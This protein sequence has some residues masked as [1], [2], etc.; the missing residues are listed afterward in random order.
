MLQ[1]LTAKLKILP[2]EQDFQ[3]LHD[4]MRAYADACSFVAQKIVSDQIP[5]SN[6]KIHKAMYK[7]CRSEFD[8]PSQ[9]SESVIRTVVASFKSIQTNLERYPHKFK[10]HKRK[11]GEIIPQFKVP[12]L[13]LVW[14]RDYS[15]VWNKERTERLFSVNTLKGRIKVPFRSDAME[16]AFAEGARFGTAKLEFKHG[17]FFLHIPVTVE[18][19]DL[20]WPSQFKNVV[21]IDRGIRFLTVA[22]DGKQTSFAS[23][24]TVKQKR[25][26]YKKKREELQKRHTPAA[27]RRIHSMGQR[28]N[29]WMNDVNH[30]LSKALV[31]DNP[32]GTLFV[33]EDL[34]GIRSA[35]ERV[36]TEDRY[37]SVSWS[38]YDLE[39]KLKYKA[40]RHGCKVINL[41]PAYTSQKCPLC[42]HTVKANRNKQKHVFCCKRCGY[43]TNDDRVAAM[44]L[45]RMGIKYLL[46]AQVSERDTAPKEQALL[47][48][49]PSITPRYAVSLEYKHPVQVQMYLRW[50]A[51]SQKMRI[52]LDWH[53]LVTSVMS[54]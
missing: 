52:P 43:T 39:E 12:Q 40:F 41:D 25:A 23:G 54:N 47:V 10:K 4:T 8:L 9:M 16:W 14:N 53:K 27:R 45:Q 19:D 18:I 44:N 36:R 5:L 51:F 46:E 21:G 37:V 7:D 13:S 48:R 24:N 28:E 15:I 17:K 31:L 1:T 3:L 32:E 42:G 22:Y 50:E 34:T 33:L 49:V 35:T 30:C 29:R 38:Y 2:D 26:H 20:P 6:K 11:G